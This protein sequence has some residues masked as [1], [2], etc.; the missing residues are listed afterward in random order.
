[1]RRLCGAALLEIREAD[2]MRLIYAFFIVWA[3]VSAAVVSFGIMKNMGG[4]A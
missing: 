1:M 4:I 2:N 3:A